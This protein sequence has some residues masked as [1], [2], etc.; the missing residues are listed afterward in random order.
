MVELQ[1]TEHQ[2]TSVMLALPDELLLIIIKNVAAV[3]EEEDVRTGGATRGV[4]KALVSLSLVNKHIRALAKERLFNTVMLVRKN[5][6]RR[7]NIVQLES[8]GIIE[9]TINAAPEEVDLYTP[10]PKLAEGVRLQCSAESMIPAHIQLCMLPKL[11]TMEISLYWFR[12][13]VAHIPELPLTSV[14]ISVEVLPDEITADVHSDELVR[15]G[16][17]LHAIKRLH[18]LSEIAMPRTEDIYVNGFSAEPW[19]WA[20]DLSVFLPATVIAAKKPGIRRI[21][22]GENTLVKV[23]RIDGDTLLKKTSTRAVVAEARPENDPDIL[24]PRLLPRLCWHNKWD[25]WK[26]P[27][28]NYLPDEEHVTTLLPMQIEHHGDD[29]EGAWI[30]TDQHGN[31]SVVVNV[32]DPEIENL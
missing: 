23:T 22:V 29:K 30:E 11:A 6:C 7:A 10:V 15:A 24:S 8:H 17:I 3:D 21:S 32:D 5:T 31:K 1:R 14:C 2:A 28:A 4:R 27:L 16:M 19:Q 25:S 9:F 13:F 20:G 18:K 26:E 12:G